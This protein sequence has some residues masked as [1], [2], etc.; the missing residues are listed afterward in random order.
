LTG[1][2]T[3]SPPIITLSQEEE[4]EFQTWQFNSRFLIL[5]TGATTNR[6]S[7]QVNIGG[8]S[9]SVPDAEFLLFLRLV[10]ALYESDDGYVDRGNQRGGG[11]VDEGIYPP[12]SVEPATGRLRSR[13]EAALA[14]VKSKDF[15]QVQRKRVRLSTHRSYVQINR[16]RLLSH[17]DARIRKLAARLPGDSLVA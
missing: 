5:L 6:A 7:N 2:P 14:G 8:A 12:D 11:L 16:T 9:I 10:V 17:P 3:S 4:E 13:F 15:I 1:H